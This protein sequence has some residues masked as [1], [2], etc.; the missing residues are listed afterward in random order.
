M[1]TA[2]DAAYGSTRS[3]QSVP[4]LANGSSPIAIC[5]LSRNAYSDAMNVRPF[6][7]TLIPSRVI[8]GASQ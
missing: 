3:H 7:R 2:G 6:S 5:I 1:T 4:K 8:A